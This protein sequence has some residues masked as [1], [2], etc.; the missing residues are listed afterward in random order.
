MSQ[1]HHAYV[2][3]APQVEGVARALT[4]VR[5][6]LKMEP[7][8]SPDV[9]VLRYPFLPVE[10]ARKV[11]EKVSGAPLV[12]E[13][14]VVV[15]A[16]ERLYH[17]AQNALLKVFEEPPP[18]TYLLLVVPTVGALLPTLRSRVIVLKG[19]ESTA[20]N[21][22]EAADFIKASREMRVARIK[23]LTSGK[24]DDEKRQNRDEARALLNGLEALLAEAGVERHQETLREI[25]T[26]RNYL[27][28][29]GAP[30]KLILEHLALV[31]PSRVR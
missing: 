9:V 27:F 2:I 15:I 13:H 18:N 26:L 14:K 23:K 30:V 17:E 10:E 29:K 4:W 5:E 28:D 20:P 25:V 3:E 11:S 19:I 7:Q 21:T 12:G 22:A 1:L 31:L 8:G 16:A 24:D 6:A